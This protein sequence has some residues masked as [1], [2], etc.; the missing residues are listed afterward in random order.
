MNRFML[1]SDSFAVF[2][3]EGLHNS[4]FLLSG[5]ALVCGFAG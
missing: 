2:R 1:T 3:C 4:S 5:F